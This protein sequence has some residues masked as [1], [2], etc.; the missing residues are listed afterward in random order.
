MRRGFEIRFLDLGGIVTAMLAPDRQGRF[1]NVTLDHADLAAYEE[2][3]GHFGALIGRFAN[4]IGGAAFTLGGKTYN[5]AANDHGNYPAWRARGL[6]QG[7]VGGDRGAER[8]RRSPPCSP[9]S[10]PMATRAS[11]AR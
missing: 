5:L 1:A 11:P 10:A 8:P 3:P 7:A 6:R 4:R 9:M 2:N